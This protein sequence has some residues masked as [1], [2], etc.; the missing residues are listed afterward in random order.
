MNEDQLRQMLQEDLAD[1]DQV[2]EFLPLMRQLSQLPAPD[3]VLRS[4]AHLINQLQPA[5]PRRHWVQWYPLVLLRSQVQIVSREIWAASALVLVIG[6]L[7]T[8]TSYQPESGQLAPLAILA[9]IV[10]AAGI[11]LL[12]DGRNE[13]IMELEDATPTGL[14][15]LMLARLLLIFSFDL[16]LTATGSFILAS[17]RSDL[18]LMPMILSWLVPM[19]FLSALAFFLSVIARNALF[20]III[21]LTLWTIHLLL[22]N[23]AVHNTLTFALSLPGFTDHSSRP[24]LLL[25]AGMLLAVSLYLIAQSE[26]RMGEFFA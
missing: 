2:E 8:L 1:G 23:V 10:A 9:P 7:V 14:I 6:T 20:G 25:T 18:S 11:G 12:Y 13:R 19:T 22:N 26:R 17:L 21:S 3:P 5:M 16:I 15:T 4:T 24:V